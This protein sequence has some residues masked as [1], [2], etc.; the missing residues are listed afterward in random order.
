MAK[1]NQ[2]SVYSIDEN[3]L[4]VMRGIRRAVHPSWQGWRIVDRLKAA[5]DFQTIIAED[6]Y[7]SALAAQHHAELAGILA[8]AAPV[9][10][11]APAEDVAE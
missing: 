7:L 3:G 11:S 5:D 1:K 9:D 8:A 6:E 2:E 10:V 4:E